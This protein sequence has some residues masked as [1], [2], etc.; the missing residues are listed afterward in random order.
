MA[1]KLEHQDIVLENIDFLNKKSTLDNIKT[2]LNTIVSESNTKHSEAVTKINEIIDEINNIT[3]TD[4]EAI[5]DTLTAVNNLLS[6]AGD[7]ANVLFLLDLAIDNLNA[8]ERTDTFRVTFSSETGIAEIDISKYGFSAVEDYEFFAKLDTDRN[9]DCSSVK[10]DEKTV[11][12]FV[13]DR[14]MWEFDGIDLFDA[15]E[16]ENNIPAVLHVIYKPTIISKTVTEADG[17]ETVIG[18]E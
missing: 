4:L 13:K 15:S 1:N 6:E 17:D 10:I 3:D 14:E 11:K 8:M 2:N 7:G 16:E 18:E 9:L 12:L 5:N